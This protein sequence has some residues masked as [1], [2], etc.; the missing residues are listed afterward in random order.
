MVRNNSIE[1][2]K[3]QRNDNS[4]RQRV[5]AKWCPRVSLLLLAWAGPSQ[6][7]P[8]VVQQGDTLA[9]IAQRVYGRVEHETLLV[10]A[11]GLDAGGGIPI[12]PG[13]RLEIPAVSFRRV[14]LGDTWAALATE[15]LGAPQ[16]AAVLA[17]A[18]DSKPWLLPT[19]NAEILVPYNL[20]VVAD[21]E[22]SLVDIAERFLGSQKRTWM[23]AEYN[24]LKH[25]RLDPGQVILVPL[26]ELPLTDAGREAARQPPAGRGG[27][28]GESRQDQAAAKDA[29]PALLA[30]VRG[31]RYVDAVA[32]GEGLLAGSDLTT[33]QRA[34]VQRQLLE[35][36]VAL[37][38]AGRARAA[39]R[40]WRR[41]DPRARLDPIE[42]S[43]KV[44][45]AC[46][47]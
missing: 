24:G 35:A 36:Y 28:G 14:A 37:G 21:G 44:L 10:I 2:L 15:L 4:G 47:P 9:G 29:L 1:R 39:C 13:M 40:E 22:S 33:P 31:G 20:R 46:A 5:F 43:P 18:N 25:A 16:R 23:L 11:N 6:A 27:V 26:T 3:M 7:F 30:D 19:E 42:L 32:R 38:A 17:F 45:D 8:L 12:T 34:A 41:A